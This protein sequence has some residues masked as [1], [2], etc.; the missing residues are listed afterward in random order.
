MKNPKLC[1]ISSKAS[2]I[3]HAS[4]SAAVSWIA[5]KDQK[6]IEGHLNV[7]ARFIFG[8]KNIHGDHY[9]KMFQNKENPLIGLIM[10]FMV[11]ISFI[12]G[13]LIIVNAVVA[14]IMALA[15]H[16]LS[17]GAFVVNPFS[18]SRS[19]F[20]FISVILSVI[21]L[22]LGFMIVRET[23]GTVTNRLNTRSWFMITI[24]AFLAFIFDNGYAA[25]AILVLIAGIVGYVFS[26][27]GF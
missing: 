15:Y 13:V 7:D 10:T 22:L 6:R 17:I 11:I 2:G 23:N 26:R 8:K 20:I 16:I 1:L 24:L 25:G 21:G 4:N 5:E 12:G 3:P 27:D 18:T 19:G 14:L 9:I